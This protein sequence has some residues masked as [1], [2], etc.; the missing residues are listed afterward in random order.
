MVVLA[1]MA[2]DMSTM[3]AIL[4]TNVH[5]SKADDDALLTVGEITTAEA[6]ALA[7]C[8]T[9]RIRQLIKQYRIGSWSPRLRMYVVDRA[10]LTAHLSRRKKR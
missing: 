4:K 10:R 6:A 5:Y 1:V 7:K 9:E 8:T 3:V 2:R